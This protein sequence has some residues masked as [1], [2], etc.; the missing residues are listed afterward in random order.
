MKIHSVGEVLMHAE[1]QTDGRDGCN[2]RFS[3][4]LR[5][6]SKSVRTISSTEH[7]NSIYTHQAVRS[8]TE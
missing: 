6:A 8:K 3:H 2:R 7:F 5:R 4:K 1:I